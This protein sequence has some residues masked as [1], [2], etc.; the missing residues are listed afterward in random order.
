MQY[1]CYIAGATVLGNGDITAIL[2]VADIVNLARDKFTRTSW[3]QTAQPQEK[4]TKKKP[5]ILI[6]DDSITTRELERSIL[7]SAG[8]DVYLAV[9]GLDGINKLSER[10]Y[11]LIISDVEMPRMDGFQMVERIKQSDQYKNI[12]VVMVTA[13]HKDEEKR[14]GIEVGAA[15]YIVKS[16][17]DQT[18]LIDTIVTLIG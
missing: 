8:Y 14:R 17:F 5:S 10:N 4:E 7:E 1:G 15:A 6:V 12:P 9:D 18:K 2:H 11:D 3:V 13:L 16:T